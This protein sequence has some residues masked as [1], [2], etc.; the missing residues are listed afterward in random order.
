MYLMFRLINFIDFR[1][2]LLVLILKP[3]AEETTRLEKL[4]RGS[5]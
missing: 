5:G 4:W 3:A 2:Y 1:K